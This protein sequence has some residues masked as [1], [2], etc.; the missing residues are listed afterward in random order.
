MASAPGLK[1]K[2]PA[3]A[4]AVMRPPQQRPEVAVQPASVPAP[5]AD[6][7][8]A[9]PVQKKVKMYCFKC[10]SRLHLTKDCVREQFCFVCDSSKHALT[11]CPILRLPKPTTFVA[12]FGM[13]ELMFADRKSVV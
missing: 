3:R 2:K 6:V 12:G 8:P 9:V 7:V 11:K 13:E 5:T 1:R 4:A 10:K